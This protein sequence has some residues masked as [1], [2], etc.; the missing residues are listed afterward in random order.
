MLEDSMKEESIKDFDP[1]HILKIGEFY[2]PETYL[3]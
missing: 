2:F 1:Y 3:T